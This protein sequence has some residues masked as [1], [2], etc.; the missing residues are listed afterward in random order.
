ME[1]GDSKMAEKANGN[2]RK[3]TNW[4]QIVATVAGA[5]VVGMQGVNFAEI[6]AGNSSGQKRMEVLQQ[7]LQLSRDMDK[8]LTNQEALARSNT[9]IL[10]NGAD[11]L[12]HDQDQFKLQTEILGTLRDAIKE[13]RELMKQEKGTQ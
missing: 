4:P 6:S 7:L 2:G 8:S 10:K 9:E 5:V 11:M 12:S 1:A 13:R 3:S